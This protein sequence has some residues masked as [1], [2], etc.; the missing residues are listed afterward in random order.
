MRAG[1]V[2]RFVNFQTHHIMK[3][4]SLLM[5]LVTL[6]FFGCKSD[7]ELTT[8]SLEMLISDYLK[9]KPLFEVGDF[10]IEKQRL[11][12]K[13]DKELIKVI[14]KLTEEG[15]VQ[16]DNEKTRKKWFSKDSVYVIEPVL[17]K[18]AL[19]YVVSH[20]KKKTVVK[21]IIY[22]LNTQ[23][24]SIE[25]KNETTA[26]CTAILDKEKTPFYLFGKDPNP[27]SEFITRKFRLKYDE[28]GWK[29][30]K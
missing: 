23:E 21:T 25:K 17:T 20:H 5:V 29:V 27:K 14:Q 6:F 4:Y 13:K 24:F 2:N 3:R 9:E 12:M 22:T 1:S 10:N 28:N 30:I 26:V 18:Q 15:F 8:S 7:K 19:P 11:D 16:I